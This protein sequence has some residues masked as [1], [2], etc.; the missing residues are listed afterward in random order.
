M[1]FLYPSSVFILLLYDNYLLKDS[2]GSAFTRG[3]AGQY[4]RSTPFS[5]HPP[6]HKGLGARY[7]YIVVTCLSHQA[8]RS[9]IQVILCCPK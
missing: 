5:T 8:A 3:Y 4:K 9:F 6:C 2:T 7:P 1:V